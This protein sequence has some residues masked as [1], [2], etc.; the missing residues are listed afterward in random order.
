MALQAPEGVATLVVEGAADIGVRHFQAV[1][2]L[3][4]V[5][6]V[7]MVGKAGLDARIVVDVVGGLVADKG[8]ARLFAAIVARHVGGVGRPRVVLDGVLGDP[9]GEVVVGLAVAQVEA[10]FQVRVEAITE[11]GDDALA[12][13][14]GVILIAVGAGIGQGH[15]VVEV[16]QHL[17]GTDLAL[18]IAVA[19]RGVAHL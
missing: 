17:P 6:G 8:A 10:R 5:H 11:V 1:G 15:V 9:A 2:T 13:A 16:A 7:V 12:V 3:A 4:Q 19:A 18:L 14:G